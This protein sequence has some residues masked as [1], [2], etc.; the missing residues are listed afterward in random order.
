[1]TMRST[2]FTALTIA[3][4]ATFMLPRSA[5]A[6]SL[7]T[8]S[9]GDPSFGGMK[10]ATLTIPA[11]WKL[12]GAML[13]NPCESIPWAVFR[14][15]SPDGL[16]EMRAMPVFGWRW[17]PNL[18]MDNSGCLPLTGP[19]TAAEFLAKY[20]ETIPGGV[21]VV[22]PMS[23]TPQYRQAAEKLANIANEGNN[24]L[25]ANLRSNHTFDVAALRVQTVNGSFVIEQRLRTMVECGINN[26]PGP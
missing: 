25:M 6:A 11:G 2:R 12:E 23:V 26:N 9:I 4:A 3:C 13:T 14:A 18:R 22:G 20:V 5:A 1:M 19:L 10:A 24:R 7:I 8:A 16:T 21:H 17:R 15:Y